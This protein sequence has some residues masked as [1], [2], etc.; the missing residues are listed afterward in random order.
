MFSL[1]AL[2]CV[3]PSK[4]IAT[5]HKRLSGISLIA[6]LKGIE[7]VEKRDFRIPLEFPR[8]REMPLF[9]QSLL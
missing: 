7:E 5:A 4:G 8:H 1:L 6:M 2:A 3:D 9:C